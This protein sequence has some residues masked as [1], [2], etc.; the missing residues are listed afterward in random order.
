MKEERLVLA[1]HQPNFLPY[2]GLFYK[3]LRSDIVVMSEDVLFSKKGMHN[4]NRIYTQNGP[5][6]LTVPVN[7][8]HDI[9]LF[10]ITVSDHRYSLPKVAKTLEQEYKKAPHFVEGMELVGRILSHATCDELKMVDLNVDLILFLLDKFD[11]HPTVLR[12]SRDLSVSGHKD[13]RMFKMCEQTGANVYFSGTGAKAYHQEEEYERRGI[14]LE[15]S[16]YQPI[17]YNQVHGDFIEN[18]SVVDY[19]FNMGYELPEGWVKDV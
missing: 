2:M 17:K 13:E 19:I 8:H 7:A 1:S 9:P 5:K 6:K 18:L 15:Y 10:E 12:T 11:M 3:V 14:C 16:D 4:W